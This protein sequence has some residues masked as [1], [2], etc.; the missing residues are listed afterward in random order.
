MHRYGDG[1]HSLDTL[2]VGTMSHSHHVESPVRP[3]Y[4]DDQG[5]L[6]FDDPNG[7]HDGHKIVLTVEEAEGLCQ[8]AYVRGFNAGARYEPGRR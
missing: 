7:S 5:R 3:A 6:H 8:K 2:G 1:A 4:I